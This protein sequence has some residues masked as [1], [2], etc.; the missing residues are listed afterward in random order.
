LHF[1]KKNVYGAPTEL[2]YPAAIYSL[3]ARIVE[4]VSIDASHFESRDRSTPQG[5]KPKPQPK[6][7]GRKS[8]VEQEF[9]QI[10]KQEQENQKTIY[11]KAIADQLDIQSPF[12]RW[13]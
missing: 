8:K 6:K 11:E 7:R 13:L 10:E 1:S 9:F 12:S 4:R 2:N 3:V 5:K